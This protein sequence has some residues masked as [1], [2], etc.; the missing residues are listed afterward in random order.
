MEDLAWVTFHITEDGVSI[1]EDATGILP[2]V[3]QYTSNPVRVENIYLLENYTKEQAETHGIRS[4]GG[5]VLDFDKLNNWNNEI[6]GD[7]VLS[8]EQILSQQ[9]FLHLQW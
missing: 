4:Y 2:L 5:V 6:F 8:G 1:R 7:W 9:R 3:C